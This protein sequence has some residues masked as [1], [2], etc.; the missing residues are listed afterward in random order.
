M[1]E[2]ISLKNEINARLCAEAFMEE[3]A[4]LADTQIEKL[5]KDRDDEVAIID[6]FV[7]MRLQSILEGQKI[8]SGP[9]SV[10]AGTTIDKGLLSSL[11]KGQYWQLIVEDNVVMSEIET[12]Y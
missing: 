7:F 8:L 4:G 2:N 5:A 11:S 12:I 10:K 1:R 6:H 9:K 3:T